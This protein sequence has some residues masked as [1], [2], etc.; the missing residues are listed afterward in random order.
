MLPAYQL[1]DAPD[2]AVDSS[3]SGTV[4]LP[5]DHAFM[6]GRGNLATTLNQ[7]A[8][9]IEQQLRVKECATIA[10]VDANGYYHPGL[11]GGFA[12]GMG[13]DRWYSH[14]LFN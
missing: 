10:F 5:P 11:P 1:T 3:Q 6:V 2:C 12:D 14:R 9:S 4:A 13:G 7:C 8:V